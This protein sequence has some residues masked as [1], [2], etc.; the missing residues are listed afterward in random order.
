M[1]STTRVA[2]EA[3]I[4]QNLIMNTDQ[5]GGIRRRLQRQRSEL[6]T[7]LLAIVLPAIA[8]V[9]G[10]FW[11]AAT[12]SARSCMTGEGGEGVGHA[13]VLLFVLVLASP[14]AIATRERHGRPAIRRLALP[15]LVSF[16]LS[17]VLVFMGL[18]LWWYLHN[19][20]T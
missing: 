5:L 15:L 18:Q 4:T 13:G 2:T 16:A 8:G 3:D 19:C 12:V 6:G 1:Q 10:W 7:W 14:V 20:Y 11:S 9:A 17:V